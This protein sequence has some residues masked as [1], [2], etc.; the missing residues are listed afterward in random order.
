M[1]LTDA[2]CVGDL[3]YVKKLEGSTLGPLNPMKESGIGIVVKIKTTKIYPAEKKADLYKILVRGELKDL[4][5]ES[6][7]KI[8]LD[9]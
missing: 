2:L 4:L 7:N 1:S 6:I 8:S 3:V 9:I 5:I